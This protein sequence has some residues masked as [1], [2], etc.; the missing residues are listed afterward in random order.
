MRRRHPYLV[1]NHRFKAGCAVVG[2]CFTVAACS[3]SPSDAYSYAPTTVNEALNTARS[4]GFEWEI[5]ILE[6]GIITAEEYE[7]AYSLFMKCVSDLSYV[8]N[9]ERYLDPVN[10]QQ[11]H[12]NGTYRGP[13]EAPEGKMRRCDE[14]LSLVETPYVVTTPK[15]MDGRLLARF[16]QCLDGAGLAYSGKEVNYNEFTE[17]LSDME[18]GYGPYFDCLSESVE[19]IYPHVVGVSV[20]RSE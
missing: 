6:D 12:I 19:D 17:H 3:T 2:L 11:W 10:G 5:G 20:G 13:G 7:E 14:R 15:R 4:V 9:N 1:I 8:F 16:Q 18:F